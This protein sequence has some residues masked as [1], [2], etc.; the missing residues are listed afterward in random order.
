MTAYEFREKAR[1]NLTGKWGKA[2]VI[3]LVYMLIS[4]LLS[5]ALSFIPFLGNIAI[6]V[7]EIPIVYGVLVSFIKLK[8][9]EEVGY[10]DFLETAFSSF[11]STWKVYG[12]IFLKVI[13]PFCLLVAVSFVFTIL[14]AFLGIFTFVGAANASSSVVSTSLIF[15]VIVAF[16]GVAAYIGIYVWL[17]IKTLLYSQSLLILYDKPNA[18]G[19]EIVEESERLM[20]GNRGRYFCLTLSFIGWIILSSLS[21][22]IGFLWLMPY[23]TIASI[24]F[25]ENLAG[26]DSGVEVVSSAS[27]DSIDVSN[28]TSENNDSLQ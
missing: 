14:T 10:L 19:K 23:M 27:K 9:N 16:I 17:I 5:F 26:K 20:K 25:Y 15:L 28:S 6:A 18:T 12:N 3:T 24:F 13:L 4:F 21:L 2:A 22:G 7:I 1:N 11:G 8:R